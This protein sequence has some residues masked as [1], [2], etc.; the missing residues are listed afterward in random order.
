MINLS[1]WKSIAQ[2][3]YEYMPIVQYRNSF[4][5]QKYWPLKKTDRHCKARFILLKFA[6]TFNFQRLL[7][8]IQSNAHH[9]DISSSALR[10]TFLN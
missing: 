1:K 4:T 3:I 9:Y 8:D 2:K 10:N 6:N 7:D 5:T